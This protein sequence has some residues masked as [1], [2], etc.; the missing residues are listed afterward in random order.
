MCHL[1]LS[2]STYR[3][4]EYQ[5]NYDFSNLF[6]LIFLQFKH[7]FISF[8]VNWGYFSVFMLFTFVK[9]FCLHRKKLKFK[10]NKLKIFMPKTFRK[11]PGVFKISSPSQPPPPRFILGIKPGFSLSFVPLFIIL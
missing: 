7:I 5:L 11:L 4:L 8:H 9:I 1:P 2:L 10:N 6:Y 3:Q